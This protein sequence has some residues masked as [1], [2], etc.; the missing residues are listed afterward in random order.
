VYL[1]Y[2]RIRL[3]LFIIVGGCIFCEGEKRKLHRAH[4]SDGDSG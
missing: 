3:G 4:L 1:A 2:I